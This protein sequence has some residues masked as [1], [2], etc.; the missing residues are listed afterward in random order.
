MEWEKKW[1][2]TYI[3]KLLFPRVDSCRIKALRQPNIFNHLTN[4][5]SDISIVKI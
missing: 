1:H 5:S 3:P 2:K 4:F